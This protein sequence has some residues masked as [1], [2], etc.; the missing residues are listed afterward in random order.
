MGW[1]TDADVVLSTLLRVC[2]VRTPCADP[3]TDHRGVPAAR[4]P[5]CRK[6]A[7]MLM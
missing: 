1:L 7:R 6:A 4:L 5:P 2:L 3:I